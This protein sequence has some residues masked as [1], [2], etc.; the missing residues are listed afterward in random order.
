MLGDA[1]DRSRRVAVLGEMLELG[2]QA[3]ALHEDVGRAAA[4][5][6]VDVLIAV[7]GEPARALADAAVAAGLPRANGHL[8]RD[9]RRGRRRRGER[10]FSAAISCSSRDRAA[11]GPI[12]SWIG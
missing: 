10:S 5:A 4:R 3:V 2:E 6:K 12:A 9:E 1:T 8:R 11:C 7:G